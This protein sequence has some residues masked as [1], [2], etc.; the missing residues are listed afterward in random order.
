MDKRETG[1]ELRLRDG[2]KIICKYSLLLHNVLKLE[3]DS[4]RKIKNKLFICMCIKWKGGG[5]I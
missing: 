1:S 3:I 4:A 5:A 2:K